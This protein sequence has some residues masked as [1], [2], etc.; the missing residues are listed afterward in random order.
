MSRVSPL[1]YAY[2][3]SRV[4][5][6][7]NSLIGREIFRQAAEADAADALKL[8]AEQGRYGER[9]L[10]AG[11]SGELESALA[12]EKRK[13]LSL[14]DS[15]LLDKRL[16]PLLD[17][18]SLGAV[19]AVRN[20]DPGLFLEDYLD[21]VIDLHNIKTCLRL[22]AAGETKARLA[23]ILVA[24]GFLEKGFFIRSYDGKLDDW[25]HGLDR[26]DKRGTRIRYGRFF[27]EAIEEVEKHRSFAALERRINDFLI[28]TL[29]PA[30]TMVFG[31]E[32]LLAYCRAR[33]NEMDLIRLVV[34]SKMNLV[35]AER[36][37]SRLNDVYA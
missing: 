7:E 28:G 30:R 17:A 12:E 32:P 31:P 27:R 25:L 22:R 16:L 33:M 19:V 3:V 36:I 2:A 4:R 18:D 29:K 24:G 35:P 13:L 37:Q 9:L 20:G 21:H 14:I 15:L 23:E 6:L 8:L 11:D 34:L 10:H 26:A 5:V 1:N